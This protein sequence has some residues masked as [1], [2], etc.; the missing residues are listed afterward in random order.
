MP[1]IRLRPGSYWQPTPI[2][3]AWPF[4][5]LTSA[6]TLPLVIGYLLG[7]PPRCHLR[8]AALRVGPQRLIVLHRQ[9]ITPALLLQPPPQFP[10]IAVHRI[11]SY[12]A[13][14]HTSRHRAADHPLGQLCFGAEGHPFRHT[15]FPPPR[16]VRRPFLGQVELPIQKGRAATAAIGQKHPDLTVLHLPRRAAVLPLHPHRLLA[17]LQEPR[18]IH[19]QHPSGITQMLHHVPLQVVPNLVRVPVVHRQQPLHPIGR[20]VPSVFGQLPSILA[21]HRPQQ[22]LQV[23]QNPLTRLTA[24]ETMGDTS[25]QRPQL[26]F[27]V[28]RFPQHILSLQQCLTHFQALRSHQ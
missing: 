17:L 7:Q 3:E 28:Q 10:V 13:K 9:H 16:P 20:G 8:R 22:S 14:G 18:L 27:L 12:P 24:A 4:A 2:V 26:C 5:A 11:P 23:R 1:P 6:Q 15:G 21:L 19:Y 25:V